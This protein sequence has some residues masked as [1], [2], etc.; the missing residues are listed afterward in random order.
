MYVHIKCVCMYVCMYI[1]TYISTYV[2]II[3][4]Y[5]GIYVR[6]NMHAYVHKYIG[7]AYIHTLHTN[8]RMT[9]VECT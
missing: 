6:T 8:E 3:C 7:S 4:M 9:Y 2:C 1:G 5:C